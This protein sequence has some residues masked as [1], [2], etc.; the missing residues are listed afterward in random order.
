MPTIMDYLGISSDTNFSKIDGVSLFPLLHNRLIEEKFAFSETGNPLSSEQ[1]PKL[2]N[3]KSIRTSEWKFIYNAFNDSKE[4]YNLKNDPS[5][6]INLFGKFPEI[7][8][9]FWGKLKKIEN[10]IQ[11]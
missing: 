5:E 8:E 7:E 6:S 9:K 2:P 3:T 4:L 11:A 10:G 1:P